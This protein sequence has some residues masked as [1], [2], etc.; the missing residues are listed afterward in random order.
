[1]ASP[2]NCKPQNLLTIL[3]RYK[4]ENYRLV[5]LTALPQENG[6]AE[7][8]YL[9][10]RGDRLAQLNCKTQ[11]RTINSIYSLFIGADFPERQISSL[12]NLKFTGNPNLNL[13]SFFTESKL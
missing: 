1:M 12:F 6:E 11:N 4:K 10:A 7:L 9:L 3:A 8:N 5:S 13:N 2:K